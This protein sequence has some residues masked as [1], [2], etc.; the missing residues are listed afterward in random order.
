MKTGKELFNTWAANYDQLLD[1]GSASISFEGYEDVLA[2]TVVQAQ[3]VPGMHVLDL[4]TGTG[5]LAAR[6]V[7]A[8]CDVW[9]MDFS[10][11]MLAKARE[12]LPCLHPI[13]ADLRDETWPQ[14][15]ARRYDRIVSAYVWHDFDLDT[16]LGLLKRLTKGYL[17]SQG[18]VLIADIAYQDQTARAQA[19]AYWGSLWS[20]GEH[21]WAADETIAVCEAI[22]LGCTYKQVSSCAGV[23]VIELVQ[24][25]EQRAETSYGK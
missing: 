2:E 8:G 5:N 1:S 10:E 22:G 7:S 13:L 11:A 18:R 23:F 4:G 25:R 6:F 16:K 12:K 17:A 24:G 14:S 21:Y 3:L 9:G 20:E 19:Q 15:L